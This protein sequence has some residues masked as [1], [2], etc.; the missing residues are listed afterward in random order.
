MFCHCVTSFVY[1]K[2]KTCSVKITATPCGKAAGCVATFHINA[3]LI[4]HRLESIMLP[5]LKTV[6]DNNT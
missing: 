6:L 1:F 2:N 4:H 3:M 5:R